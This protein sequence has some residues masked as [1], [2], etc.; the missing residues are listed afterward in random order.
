M[1]VYLCVM[2]L[3]AP[4]VTSAHAADPAPQITVGTQ[5]VGLSAGYL[6]PERLT[7]H[8]VTKQQGPAFM[9]S[10]MITLTDPIGDGWYRGQVSIGAE[11][12]Y[13]QFQEPVLTHGAD[14]IRRLNT[15]SW[16]TTGS[17]PTLNLREA[18]SGP[19]SATR[20]RKNPPS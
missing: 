10:W 2:A 16:Q 12:V 14:L 13:I 7:K 6:L 9:P 8:H 1:F 4:F 5:E 19:I 20:S 11:V 15:P 3:R 17:A 18:P